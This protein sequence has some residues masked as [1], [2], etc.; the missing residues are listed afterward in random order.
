MTLACR[1]SSVNALLRFMTRKWHREDQGLGRYLR[2]RAVDPYDDA[3]SY[4]NRNRVSRQPCGFELARAEEGSDSGGSQAIGDAC[5]QRTSSL[6]RAGN[7]GV[8][9]V[10]DRAEGSRKGSESAL[11]SAPPVAGICGEI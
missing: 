3:R 2:S 1:L 8:P 9:E 10:S 5:H 6:H 7:I 4:K 11:A